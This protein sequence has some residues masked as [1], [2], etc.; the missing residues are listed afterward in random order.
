MPMVSRRTPPQRPSPA[1]CRRVH[2]VEHELHIVGAR[3]Q[4]LGRRRGAQCRQTLHPH[5]DIAAGMLEV[6]DEKARIAPGLAPDLAALAAAAQA[7]R[8]QQQRPR[9]GTVGPAHEQGQRASA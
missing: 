9:A 4:L 1:R 3:S 6:D 7:V 5:R 8:E 2:L